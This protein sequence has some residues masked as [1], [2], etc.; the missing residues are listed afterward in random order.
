MIDPTQVQLQALEKVTRVASL[1]VRFWDA[2]SGSVIGDGLSVMAY[3]SANPTVT[4]PAYPNRSGTYVLQNVPG[5]RAIENG[6]GDTNFWRDLP[7]SRPFVI[8]VIDRSW[9]F[10]P[11]SFTAGLPARG[12]F[13][14]VCGSPLSGAAMVPL[15]SSPTRPVPGGMAVLRADLWDPLAHVPASWA[16]LSA[17]AAGQ[18]LAG[19]FAD[20]Y[21]RVALIF[22]YPAPPG[23][24]D[25]DS[26]DAPPEIVH[27]PLA[28]QQWSVQLEAAYAPLFPVPSVPDLC[29]T[30]TQRL[31]T[32]W[33]DSTLTQPLTGAMLTFGQELIVRS[34][35][36]AQPSI[37]LITPAVPPP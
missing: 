9:R 2:V 4:V 31:A 5:L 20:F 23:F 18:L 29:A 3:P 8:E 21:G 10:Q 16:F 13:T 15:Y 28:Q 17:S 32:L 37:L 36:P 30:L 26:P 34:R 12:L 1:G 19:G 22:P 24:V 11:F 35:D 33:V 27:A 25:A 6:T 7:T 14:W